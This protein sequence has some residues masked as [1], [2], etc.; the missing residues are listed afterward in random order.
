MMSVSCQ[1]SRRV[2]KD[3]LSVSKNSQSVSEDSSTFVIYQP[4]RPLVRRLDE[5]LGL[6]FRNFVP[7]C[8]ED[9]D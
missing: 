1:K 5:F 3:S 2:L 4:P 8:R 7:E 9:V 6:G